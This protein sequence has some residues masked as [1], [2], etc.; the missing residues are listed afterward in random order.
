MKIW[1]LVAMHYSQPYPINV[2]AGLG[3]TSLKVAGNDHWSAHEQNKPW[4]EWR[5]QQ[6]NEDEKQPFHLG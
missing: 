6:R 3:P 4:A 1:A 2:E 5:E